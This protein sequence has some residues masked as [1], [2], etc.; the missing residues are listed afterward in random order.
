MQ[1]SNITQ[2]FERDLKVKN[3]SPR[4]IK[5]YI[6]QVKMFL[7]YFK[8]RDSP[9]HISADDIKNYLL[10]AK[11]VNSQRHMHS[12]IKCLYKYTVHQPCKF[13]FIEYARKEKRLPQVID[14]EFLLDRI[15]KIDNI[16]HKAIMT[17]AYSTGMRVG[18]I[19]NLKIT[20][21][22]SVRMI[23]TVRQG[24]GR[25][26]RIVPLST[27]TLDTLR[28]Y[29]KTCK[30]VEYLFNG[31]L[32][33]SDIQKNITF[34]PYTE[35]SCNQ[36]VKKYLGDQYHMHLLR[37]SSFTALMEAGTD[38]RVIQSIAGHSSSKTTEIY[39]HVSRH[40]I[41]KIATPI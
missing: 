27:V 26:D 19:I 15:S 40:Y 3:Y 13:K 38:I 20:D 10:T 34:V 7:S 36:I 29:Y 30:P 41:S 1:I 12:A 35:A 14:K 25:K 39:T 11:E 24:K 16:K 28:M 33:K 32:S 31:Q 17:L 5:N 23:I 8:D 37:H 4:S 9:K 6:T 2:N 22:D 18:E 21:I